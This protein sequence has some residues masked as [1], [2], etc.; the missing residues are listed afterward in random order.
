MRIRSIISLLCIGLAALA[1]FSSG[2]GCA[3]IVPPAGGARDSLAPLRV[4]VDPGDSSRFFKDKRITFTF[5]EYV[6]VANVQQNLI[7]SPLPKIQPEVQSRLKTVTVRLRDTLEENTT[8]SINFNKIIKD[9]NEGNELK[10]FVYVF[11]TGKDFDSLQLSG[12]VVLAENAGIDTTLTVMLHRNGDDSA[13]IKERPRYIAKL[14]SDGQFRFRFLK[15]GTY[16]IYALK[17][18][19][20][21][22]QYRRKSQLFAFAD[23]AI[24]VKPEAAPVKLYAYATPDPA[25]TN[26][27]STT[28]KKNTADKRL[29]FQTSLS[30]TQD[31]LSPVSLTFETPLRSFD[32]SKVLF[33]TDT[34]FTPVT[35]GYTWQLDS[36]KKIL[37]F[38]YPWKENTHYAFILQKEFATDTMG[39]QLLK[40]DTVDFVS[41]KKAEYGDL[42]IRFRNLDLSVN[43]VL[44]FVQNNDVKKSV[45]LTA[46]NMQ[47]PLFLPGEYEL[48]IVKDANKNGKWD[49]GDFFGK[50]IQPE[51]VIPIERKILIKANWENEFEIDVNA[52]ATPGKSK[53]GANPRQPGNNRNNNPVRQSPVPTTTNPTL[54]NPAS[55]L[56][57]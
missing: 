14:D 34:L 53:Q 49:A 48:R 40:T 6:E 24:V 38:S 3:N 10:D 52:V 2:T 9:V 44:L 33:T 57:D 20:G 47:D 25:T 50:H 19:G 4:K 8:Y 43:P 31:L 12:S 28:T 51:K 22:Y 42:K 5:D 27:T 26:T 41:K 1:F 21:Q 37:T 55:R 36:T 17:D 32:S 30:G 18:E 35:S 15:A 23:S 13:V 45:P 46:V 11:S 29:K 39:Y 16:Y 7:V 54:N 56:K